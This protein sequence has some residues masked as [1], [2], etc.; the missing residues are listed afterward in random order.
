M[1]ELRHNNSTINNNHA[2]QSSSASSAKTH[3]MSNGTSGGSGGG[4]NFSS[5]QN[6]NPPPLLPVVTTTTVTTQPPILMTLTATSSLPALSSVQSLSPPSFVIEFWQ[7][8]DSIFFSSRLMWL[9]C[10]GPVAIIGYS[11]ELI[12]EDWAFLLAGIALIPCAERY[13]QGQKTENV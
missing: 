4:V 5:F 11:N 12:S 2:A 8:L 7:S 3:I 10:F 6:D 9:L 13:V 1:T